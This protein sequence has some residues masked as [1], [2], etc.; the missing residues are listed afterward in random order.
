MDTD[1]KNIYSLI[2][3]IRYIINNGKQSIN[4]ENLKKFTASLQKK[5]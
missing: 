3:D 1:K 4:S 2:A 5:L